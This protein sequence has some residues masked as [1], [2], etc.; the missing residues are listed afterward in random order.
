MR[1]SIIIVFLLFVFAQYIQAQSIRIGTVRDE[2][3]VLLRGANLLI[4][5]NKINIRTDSDGQFNLPAEVDSIRIS[6]VGYRTEVFVI[7]AN[8]P[9]IFTLTSYSQFIEEVQVFT[10]Y[11][12]LTKERQTGSFVLVD[13]KSLERRSSA[14]IMSRLED[15]ATGLLFDK[16]PTGSSSFYVRGQSTINSEDRPLII[17]D[18]FPYEGDLKQINPNDIESVT[19]LKDAAAASIWG[20][21][22]G[23]GV[24]VLRTK[25]ARIGQRT[26]VDFKNYYSI[27]EKPDLRANKNYLPSEPYIDVERYLFGNG[28]YADK[29]RD[30]TYPVLSPVI[31]LLISQRENAI[32]ADELESQLN[33]L[34]QLDFRDELSRHVYRQ[35]GDLQSALNIRAGSDRLAY[36]FSAGFDKNRSE[37]KHMGD[38]RVDLSLSSQFNIIPKLTYHNTFSYVT[39]K[40]TYD[41]YVV[42]NLYGAMAIAP[43]YQRLQDEQ[44]N[45]SMLWKDYRQRYIHER[46]AEGY[47]DWAF[48]PLEDLKNQKNRVEN[49]DIRINNTLRYALI[50]GLDIEVH[51]QYDRQSLDDRSM[52]D[53]DLYATRDLINRFAQKDDTRFIYPVPLGG[54]LDQRRQVRTTHSGRGQ[55][56]LNRQWGEHSLAGILGAEWRKGRYDADGNRLYGYNDNLLTF[57]SVDYQGYYMMNPQNYEGKI[58]NTSF[59]NGKID[60]FVSYYGN[61]GYDL[62]GRYML[63]VSARKDAS[64]IFGVRTNQKGVPLWSSGLSWNLSNEP[65]YDL[66]QLPYIKIRT[67]Y[68]LSGNVNRSLTAYSTG[69]YSVSSLTQQSYI[70]LL[71]PPNA[72]LRWEKISTVNLGLDFKIKDNRLSGSLDFYWKDAKDLIGES[73][74][75]PTVGF[76]VGGRNTFIGNNARMKGRGV[77]LNLNYHKKWNKL[78]WSTTVNYSFST[79]RIVKYD[80]ENHL[81]AY[82][83][84]F[85]A[86]MEGRSRFSEYVLAWGG[87]DSENGDPRVLLG[88][89]PWKDYGNFYTKLVKEDIKYGGAILPRHFGSVLTELSYNDFQ[90]SIGLNYKFGHW[91]RQPTINYTDLFSRGRGHLDYLDRWQKEG[92][93][94]HTDIPSRPD[95]SITPMRDFVYQYADVLLKRAD[96]IRLKDVRLSYTFSGKMRQA[97][98]GVTVFGY[99]DNVGLMWTA[100]KMNIDPEYVLSD[101]SAMRSYVLGLDIKF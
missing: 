69:Y 38:K 99:V 7:D 3:G 51:Y 9:L 100:N 74:L 47:P 20:A 39:A 101:Y 1:N 70:Q 50:Q 46:R 36:S 68:G 30:L 28:Y 96:H 55:T 44:G 19:I 71:T 33:L 83:S 58:P 77:D 78:D 43:P 94:L 12:G 37:I 95:P 16:R 90:L 18:N 57:S 97:F 34:K 26:A 93:E 45:S 25:Q 84:A 2:Q 5:P 32:T 79:D 52:Q 10:G 4:Y 8:T 35:R 72:D 31:E 54:I 85:N 73:P 64:N 22:A 92:D 67:T 21:R 75:D 53:Q 63:S 23:N 6:K 80:F 17:L 42:Q 29:E 48:Y 24:V 41:S 13:N 56:S 59:L 81:S 98:R 89:E 66:K 86:P 87:L 91:F 40:N 60:R 82:F 14:D 61:V 88:G 11:Q 27:T 76:S 62:K 15:R 65:W 49:N